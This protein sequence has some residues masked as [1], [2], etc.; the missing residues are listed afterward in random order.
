MSSPS[1]V[2]KV[3]R[4][5][6][7][8]RWRDSERETPLPIPNR[9]VKPL[10]ADGTWWA[11]AWES[12]SP[13]V[14]PKSRPPGRLSSFR[15]EH[16][17]APCSPREPRA[18][19]IARSRPSGSSPTRSVPGAPP[20]RPSASPPSASGTASP[21]RAWTPK[22]EPFDGYSSFAQPIAIFLA[23]ALAPALLPRRSRLRALLSSAALAGWSPRGA[24]AGCRSQLPSRAA[25]ARTW[26]P[27]SSPAA[28][29]RANPLPVWP[30]RHLAVRAHVPPA[31]RAV[32][33]ALDQSSDGRR[34]GR[35]RWRAAARRLADRPRIL[36][37]GARALVAVGAG[38]AAERELRGSD[39]PGAN[40][41]ASGTA[42]C[43]ELCREPRRAAARRAPGSFV[44]LTGCEESGLL[45][46]QAF[47]RA[48]DTSGW[49]FLNFDNVGAGGPST[50]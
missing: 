26:S 36:V 17:I 24:C 1:A 10:S 43:V 6:R 28:K 4:A 27:R 40:D 35:R 34:R 30:P 16:M 3:H 9:A 13:P 29:R 31:F 33:D 48:R 22:L 20:A 39:V 5:S 8:F 42:V 32:A 45:G 50:T 7:T 14:L 12:R 37:A 46:A 18:R 25:R 2:F 47:L 38:T 11:T 15:G 23:L 41:N 49:L 21:T 19:L 44:L